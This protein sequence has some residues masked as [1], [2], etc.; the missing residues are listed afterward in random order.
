MKRIAILF[1]PAVFAFAVAGAQKPSI[2]IRQSFESADTKPEPATITYTNPKGKASSYLVDA[3]FGISAAANP[4][5]TITGLVEYHRNTL[6]DE[7]TNTLQAGLSYELFANKEFMTGDNP[8]VNGATT[9]ITSTA[10][11]SDNRIDKVRSFQLSG[12]VTRLYAPGIIK[13]FV[14]NVWHQV[15]KQLAIEYF[16]SV[17]FEYE[18][19]FKTEEAEQKGSILRG[20]GKLNISIYPLSGALNNNAELFFNSAYR[21]DVI[22][23]TGEADRTHPSVETGVNFV[24]FRKDGKKISLGG[25]YNKIDDPALGKEKQEFLLIALKVKI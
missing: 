6:V 8:A 4:R 20:M 9:I 13:G 2:K 22:N 12:E 5:Q 16:P 11:Y 19:R 23:S 25:S 7:E 15:G 10:K 3:A 24:F 14:P 17:G 18:G 21:H 1:I